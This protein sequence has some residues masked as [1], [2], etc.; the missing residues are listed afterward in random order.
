VS[1][2]ACWQGSDIPPALDHRSCHP[3]ASWKAQTH[4]QNTNAALKY[5]EVIINILIFFYF[6]GKHLKLIM[7]ISKSNVFYFDILNGTKTWVQEVPGLIT[8]SG[9]GFYVW[10][11]VLLLLCFY[12]FVQKHIIYHKS[13]QF[14]LQC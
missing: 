11:F 8:G 7:W 1:L 12:F 9:K 3:G 10:F 4:L 6:F 13:L 14:L 2:A 5:H